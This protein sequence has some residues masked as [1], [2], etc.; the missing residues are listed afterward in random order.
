VIGVS[1]MNRILEVDYP[2]PHRRRPGRRDQHLASA[3]A[4]DADGFFYA[5]DP[6][7]QLAC[8]IGGNIGMNSG[9]AHCLKYG[10]TT[11]NLLG[12]KMVMHDGSIVEIGGKALDAEGYRPARPDLRLGRPARHRHRGHGPADR[13]AGRRPAGAVRLR[14]LRCRRRLRHRH[15]R[16][17]HHPGRH[18]IHG[19]AGH[20]DLR[21]LCPCRLSDG[22][23]GA[24][25]RRGRGLRRRDG[26]DA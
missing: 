5:P 6:S 8:T 12:V 1:K 20:R 21:G 2:Q 17:G 13:Q 22:C 23:R 9:G 26:R 10:V 16:R 25:D 14:F 3:R 4:V 18:R 11:N 19:Q 24:A 7:S 15:H